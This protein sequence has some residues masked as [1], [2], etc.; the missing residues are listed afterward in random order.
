MYDPYKNDVPGVESPA[1]NIIEITP[2]DSDEIVVGVKS[3]RLFNNSPTLA[4]ISVETSVGEQITLPIPGGAF[5]VEP[6]RVRK[7]FFTGTSASLII[8]G[9]TDVKST[10]KG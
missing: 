3:L 9:Y 8:H 10:V 5:Y 4:T 2:S 7:V 6:L 1:A